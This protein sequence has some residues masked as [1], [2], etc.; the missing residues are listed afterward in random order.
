MGSDDEDYVEPKKRNY[1]CRF[2]INPTINFNRSSL[3]IN[4]KR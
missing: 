3:V 2:L 1:L 4:Q